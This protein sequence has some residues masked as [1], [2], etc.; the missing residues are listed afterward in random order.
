MQQHQVAT[1]GIE[2]EPPGWE[3]MMLST[4]LKKLPISLLANISPE[5]TTLFPLFLDRSSNR[6]S[7]QSHLNGIVIETTE[8]KSSEGGS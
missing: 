6:S 3:A 5:D 8:Y 4:E 2:P 7:D 1:P